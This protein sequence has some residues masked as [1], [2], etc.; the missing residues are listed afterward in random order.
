MDVEHDGGPSA[1]GAQ[2]D[3]Q[4]KFSAELKKVSAKI[5]AA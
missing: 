5:N 2:K 4:K 1:W 3:V